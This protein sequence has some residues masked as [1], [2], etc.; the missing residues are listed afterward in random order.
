MATLNERLQLAVEND[1]GEE[2]TDIL[3]GTEVIDKELVSKLLVIA[4]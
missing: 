2:I 3:G 1:D 4:S